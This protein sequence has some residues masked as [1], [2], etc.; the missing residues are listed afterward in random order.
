MRNNSRRFDSGAA[1][2]CATRVSHFSASPPGSSRH[3]PRKPRPLRQAAPGPRNAAAAEVLTAVVAAGRPTHI[4]EETIA[5]GS[6]EVAEFTGVAIGSTRTATFAFAAVL[7]V[8]RAD[9]VDASHGAASRRRAWCPPRGIRARFQR[10]RLDL[11]VASMLCGGNG[12]R[13][14]DPPVRT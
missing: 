7:W 9:E 14:A 1:A 4:A 3:H 11:R 10:D 13:P 5:G 6:V 2:S 12:V 8:T